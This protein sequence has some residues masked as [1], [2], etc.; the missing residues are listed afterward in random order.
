MGEALLRA[1]LNFMGQKDDVALLTERNTSVGVLYGNKYGNKRANLVVYPFPYQISKLRASYEKS[2]LLNDKQSRSLGSTERLTI[3]F[4][5]TGE[6]T[7]VPATQTPAFTTAVEELT[8]NQIFADL[9]RRDIRK[10]GIIATDPLDVVFLARQLG[11]FCP[12]VQLFTTQSHLLFTHP[13]HVAELRGMLVA[14]TYPLYPLNQLWSYSYKGDMAHTFFSGDTVQGTYNAAVAHLDQIG[15]PGVLPRFL[16][17][18]TPF[19][20]PGSY[21]KGADGWV[22]GVKLRKP[23]IWLSVVGNHG[24]YPVATVEPKDNPSDDAYV[25]THIQQEEEYRS[26]PLATP[27]EVDKKEASWGRVRDWFRP[28]LPRFWLF[29]FWGLTLACAALM[30]VNLMIFRWALGSRRVDCETIRIG[31][32]QTVA[33]AQFLNCCRGNDTARGGACRGPGLLL[34]IALLLLGIVY[35]TVSYPVLEVSWNVPWYPI[36]IGYGEFWVALAAYMTTCAM[37]VSL[38]LSVLGWVIIGRRISSPRVVRLIRPLVALA[39]C[40]TFLVLPLGR[41]W[42]AWSSGVAAHSFATIEEAQREALF[43]LSR[44]AAIPSGVSPVLSILLLG[45]AGLAWVHAQLRRR[46]IR[47]QYSPKVESFLPPD[48]LSGDWKTLLAVSDRHKRFEEIL[49]S[50]WEAPPRVAGGRRTRWVGAI[51]A[52]P[53]VRLFRDN[54]AAS[55]VISLISA[56]FLLPVLSRSIAWQGK[57]PD[58]SFLGWVAGILFCVLFILITFHLLQVIAL[59]KNVHEMMNLILRLPLTS[60]LDRIPTRVA[61]WFKE[62]PGSG[63]RRFELIRRQS[64]ALA[65]SS[66]GGKCA[67]RREL[68]EALERNIPFD[69]WTDLVRSLKGVERDTI[70]AIRDQ[71]LVL[72]L[73]YWRPLPVVAAFATKQADPSRPDSADV[74][75]PGELRNIALAIAKDTLAAPESPKRLPEWIRLAEDL[76]ALLLMR[77]LAAS[78]AQVWNQIG[79]LAAGAMALLL[80]INAYP[81]PFQDRLMLGIGLLIVALVATILVIVVGFNRDEMINRISNTS[82]NQLKLDQHLLGILATYVVPLVGV[83]AAISFDASD[84]IRTL[85]DPIL[86]HFR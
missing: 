37:A 13:Q 16:E 72:V 44:S 81:Y 52:T 70:D 12:D 24:L 38:V 23:P 71:L 84:T 10:V 68:S 76:V 3:P 18:G 43:R 22:W 41:V 65:A 78:C 17:Y 73:E 31:P 5:V 58:G 36:D 25:F 29:V 77:W 27:T 14:S 20:P 56:F 46:F 60:A 33:L 61:A 57:L 1:A 63:N 9:R 11:T 67:V 54:A 64:L 21:K 40:V 59:W 53:V 83:L 4:E 28:S 62:P 30:A 35:L 49:A 8:L 50:D 82:P 15:N 79:F 39:L 6:P 32:I 47:D 2:G 45:A 19:D 51:L 48:N 7:D 42:S 74:N 66:E 86:R 75:V 34:T 85:F 55:I 69:R 80:A 26:I